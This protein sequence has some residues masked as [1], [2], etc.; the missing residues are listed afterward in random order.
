MVQRP[1][2]TISKYIKKEIEK[3]EYTTFF[4]TAK[5]TT[6]H[7]TSSILQWI[8][9][10]RYRHTIKL[11]KQKMDS[12]VIKFYQSSLERSHA[13]LIEVNSEFSSRSS[14]F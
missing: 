8:R 3:K 9:Y 6:S 1:N 10:F 7:A 12:M 2:F 4:E 11:Y 14:P 13:V 5:N